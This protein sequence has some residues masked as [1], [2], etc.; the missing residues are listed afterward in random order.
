MAER[1]SIKR[2]E[3]VEV[4]EE[5]LDLDDDDLDVDEEEEEIRP[6]K[7]KAKLVSKAAPP[8]RKA[9]V[10][11]EEPD[12]E[13]DDDYEEPDEEEEYVPPKAAA[14]KVVPPPVKKTAL[15]AKPVAKPVAKHAR[16][17]EEEDVDDAHVPVVAKPLKVQKVA[18]D[19]A[20]GILTGLLEGMNN[21]MAVVITRTGEG[22]WMFTTG[23]A[24]VAAGPKLRG[25]EYWETVL[26]QEYKEW[27]EEWT[28]LTYAEKVTK[29]K[30]M[31]VT[32]DRHDDER[33][34]NIRVSAAVQAA[35]GIEKYKPEYRTR[36]AQERL[37]GK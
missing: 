30:K 8:A 6:P 37:K 7:A 32:W 10:V 9:K 29:A 21:G 19:V 24:S 28:T 2:R 36:A 16:D 15:P 20:G 17:A 26:T 23:V 4:Y 3:P 25:K 1:R 12:E 35:L 31:K 11:E 27:Q 14:R 22:K 18:A 13:E 5:D 34:D 33:V